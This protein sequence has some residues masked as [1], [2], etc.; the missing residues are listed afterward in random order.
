M[1]HQF[2]KFQSEILP[3]DATFIVLKLKEKFHNF[4]L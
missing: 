3:I 1:L 2:W 4:K